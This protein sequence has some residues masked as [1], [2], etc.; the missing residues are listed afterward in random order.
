MTKEIK[1]NAPRLRV[2]VEEGDEL[3]QYD[4]QT[5][6]RDALRFDLIRGRKG[7][8]AMSDAPMLWMSC[9]AW[10]ALKRSG[11]TSDD[12]EDYLDKIVQ[13]TTIDDD[14]EPVKGDDDSQSAVP[15][16]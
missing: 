15:L 12:V 5:D 10:H 3:K 13:L 8:P 16:G 6:N 7:W 14:G 2:I 4:V 1:L 11:V 9:L